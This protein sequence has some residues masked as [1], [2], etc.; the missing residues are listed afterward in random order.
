MNSVNS[1]KLSE[2][3]R[4]TKSPDFDVQSCDLCVM[5]VLSACTPKLVMYNPCLGLMLLPFFMGLCLLNKF[6]QKRTNHDSVCRNHETKTMIDCQR[7]TA[8]CSDLCLGFCEIGEIRT[9]NPRLWL[10]VK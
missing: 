8:F 9:H 5:P 10:L 4:G 1:S 2:D 7:I 3:R 6:A